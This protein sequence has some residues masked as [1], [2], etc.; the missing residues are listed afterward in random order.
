MVGRSASLWNSGVSESRG[1]SDAS[2]Q[3]EESEKSKAAGTQ[4]ECGNLPQ[5]SS[6][7]FYTVGAKPTKVGGF[8]VV[9][10]ET[11][12]RGVA[13]GGRP[14]NSQC[15]TGPRARV[16]EA[17]DSPPRRLGPCSRFRQSRYLRGECVVDVE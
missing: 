6:A 16:H 11:A 10:A 1:W 15:S 5:E 2:N 12:A 7:S 9:W 17:S 3:K 14:G 13:M 4:T 8:G